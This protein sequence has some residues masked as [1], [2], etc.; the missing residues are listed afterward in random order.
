MLFVRFDGIYLLTLFDLTRRLPQHVL[1]FKNAFDA[2][3][4]EVQAE[5]DKAIRCHP[6][7]H[8]TLPAHLKRL[9]FL[10]FPAEPRLLL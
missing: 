3:V 10:L 7:N 5:A 4:S 9:M 2:A 8:P 6:A 1:V